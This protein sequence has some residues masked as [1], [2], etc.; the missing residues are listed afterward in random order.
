MRENGLLMIRVDS[1]KVK[2]GEWAGT[3][4]ISEHMTL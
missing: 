4:F 3:L 1:V 2:V